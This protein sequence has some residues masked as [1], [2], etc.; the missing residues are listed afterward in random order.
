MSHIDVHVRLRPV[1][2]AFLVQPDDRKLTLEIFHVTTSLWGGRYNPI[3]PCFKEVPTWWDRHNHRFETAEQIVNGY[4]DFFEPDFIIEAEPGLADGLGFDKDRVLQLSGLLTREGDRGKQGHGQSVFDLYEDLYRNE[5]QFTR[6][7]DHDIINVAATD[8][9]FAEFCACIFGAFPTDPDLEYIQRGFKDAFEPKEILLDG[10]GLT[11]LYKSGFTSALRLGTS[12]IDVRSYD[13][14]DPAIF[15]LDAQQSRDLIDFWNLRAIRRGNVVPVPVQWLKDLSEFCK[16]FMVK[17]YRPLP[18]NSHGVMI[19]PTVMFARSIP[20]ADIDRLHAEYLHV[21]TAGGNLRQDWYPAIWRS[22]SGSSSRLMRPTLS[23]QEKTYD[24]PFVDEKPQIRFDCLVPDFAEQYGNQHRWAN[25]VRLRDWTLKNQIARA[26]PCDCRDPKFLKF[27]LGGEPILPTMEGF[28]IFPRYKNIPEVW[29]IQDG[30]AAIK[31][32][33]KTHGIA[34]VLSDAGRV[35]QQII[36]TVGGFH[37]VRSFAHADI[38]KFL[39]EI[40]R[41][42]ISRSAHHKEFK[43]RIQGATKEDI[44]RTKNFG[45]VWVLHG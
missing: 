19:H 29:K 27:G 39:N 44:W 16:E 2:F 41:R 18:G 17:N 1:R 21:D 9:T 12:K 30:V 25:V 32:W 43:N 37:G 8:A 26:Y 22:R 33:L 31:D 5:Y 15:L 11:N 23:A 24:I 4:V 42:P 40:S 28:V 34:A 10:A 36:Q 20:T 3:I 13:D 45:R 7:H 35:T 14:S 6:R 38:V